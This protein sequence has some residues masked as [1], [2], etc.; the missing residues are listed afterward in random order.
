M[1]LI[2]ANEG[3]STKEIGECLGLSPKTI[4]AH[5]LRTMRKLGINNVALLTKYALQEGL[6]TLE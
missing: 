6:T 5:R 4:E 1:V 2:C 3:R